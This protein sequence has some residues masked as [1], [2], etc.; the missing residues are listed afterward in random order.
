MRQ[1]NNSPNESNQN[2]MPNDKP[3]PITRQIDITRNYTSTIPTHHL[4][5]NPRPPLQAPPNIPTIPR[6]S[7]RNLRINPNS[8][9]HRTRILY[10]WPPRR[11]KHSKARNSHDLEAHQEDTPF[12]HAISIP[13]RSNGEEAR[14]D[15]WRDGHE[16]RVVGSVTH[17]LDDRREEQ[18]EG[19]DGAEARHADQ[20]EDVYLPVCEGLVDVFHVEVVGEVAV[21]CVEAALDFC[22]FFWGEE[23]GAAWVLDEV[24][25]SKG[26]GG[27]GR[28]GVVVYTPVCYC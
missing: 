10:T 18:G 24:V 20:H 12:L 4:H 15:V 6:H 9:Q 11:S 3:R 8:R 21:V 22:A 26:V 13:A 14:A 19:V 7:Q 25:A 2:A 17:V 16:L 1:Y 5:S 23:A 28:F 27:D